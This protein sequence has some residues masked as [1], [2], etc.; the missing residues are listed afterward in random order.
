MIKWLY[1]KKSKDND[2]E[3][4]KDQN[5]TEESLFYDFNTQQ[6]KLEMMVNTPST[7]F[8]FILYFISYVCVCCMHYAHMYCP[9]S[10]L[11][12]FPRGRVS[13]RTRS[14]SFHG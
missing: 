7:I 4:K 1:R 14:S 6:S 12:S 10:H 8:V 5:V 3:H 13:H 2:K 11:I 9:L